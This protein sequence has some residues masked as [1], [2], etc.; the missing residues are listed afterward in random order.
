MILLV[1]GDPLRPRRPDEH[2]APE[3]AAARVAGLDV[4]VVD[5]DALTR[6]GAGRAVGAVP[7]G[8]GVAVYRG[9]MLRGP[10]YAAFAE[11]LA[12]RGVRLRTT[13][14]EYRKA[15]ELP[16]WYA[17]LATVTPL[18]EWTEG[19]RRA[20]FERAR[21]GLGSGPAVLRD[22][23]KSMK[24]YWHEATF[25]PDLDDAEAGWR[26]AQRFLELREDEA[27]GGFVLRRY[28]RF[29]SAEVRTWWIDGECVLVGAHPDTPHEIPGTE[30]D[31]VAVAPLVAG[32]GLPFVTVDLALRADGVWRVV[33]LGDGQVSD[34]PASMRPEDLIARIAD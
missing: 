9:W 15:H 24:A 2:F 27:V 5:H 19:W 13:A 25:I 26:V 17:A 6:G 21:I 22:Y 20:D 30:V 34:R 4:A 12:V 7:A 14:E 16:G 10:E 18:S 3:A 8:S 33:E 1:P 29:G 32:L 28:E 31:L 23:S 11:S